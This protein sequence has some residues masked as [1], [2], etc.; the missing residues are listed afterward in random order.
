MTRRRRH[1]LARHFWEMG[2]GIVPGIDE[3]S[4]LAIRV[5]V[6]FL[7]IRIFRF[8]VRSLFDYDFCGKIIG[9]DLFS[10]TAG[11]TLAFRRRH[12]GMVYRSKWVKVFE[13]E[14]TAK[15]GKGKECFVSVT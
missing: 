3:R 13:G 1:V 5:A 8:R 11:R 15:K 4:A 12:G 6:S 10:L 9:S 14:D 7:F 2:V